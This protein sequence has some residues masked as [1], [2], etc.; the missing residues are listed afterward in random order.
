MS[1]EVCQCRH[2]RDGTDGRDGR[3]GRDGPAGPTGPTGPAG[4][5]GAQG[6]QGSQGPPGQS[7]VASQAIPFIHSFSHA[8]Q[9][10]A[11]GEAISLD[12][13]FLTSK[14]GYYQLTYTVF[15]RDP[16]QLVVY[17]NGSPAPNTTIGSPGSSH[18]SATFVLFIHES[19]SRI[20]LI[21]RSSSS[22]RLGHPPTGLD[23]SQLSAVATLMFLREPRRN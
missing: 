23:D 12:P 8:Q 21:N 3:D 13:R 4:A 19:P 5:Q 17:I 7:A 22:L 15:H 20:E 2:G 1:N 11:P 18:L 16:C 14:P 6:P 9:K 10:I